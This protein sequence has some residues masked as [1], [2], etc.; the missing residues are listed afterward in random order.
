MC[1]KVRSVIHTYIDKVCM[2]LHRNK[3]INKK[4]KQSFNNENF[5][6]TEKKPIEPETSTVDLTKILLLFCVH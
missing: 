5:I 6:L 1:C 4:S 2:V 3:R